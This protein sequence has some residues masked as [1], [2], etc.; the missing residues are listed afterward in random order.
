MVTTAVGIIINGKLLSC[1]YVEPVYVTFGSYQH[2]CIIRGCSVLSGHRS[3]N[4][5]IKVTEQINK[6]RMSMMAALTNNSIIAMVTEC[7]PIFFCMGCF[8]DK[9]GLGMC[10]SGEDSSC[11]S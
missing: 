7:Y 3:I 10:G 11:G 1:A 5:Y 2:G 9:C 6:I 4:R 8:G